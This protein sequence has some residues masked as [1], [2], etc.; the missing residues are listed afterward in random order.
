MK[1]DFFLEKFFQFKVQVRLKVEIYGMRCVT[2]G[3]G[4]EDY[5]NMEYR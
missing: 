2:W 5:D 1:K 4:N 3:G